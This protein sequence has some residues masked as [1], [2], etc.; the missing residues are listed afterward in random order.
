MHSKLVSTPVYTSRDTCT[1]TG[2]QPHTQ[3]NFTVQ[4]YYQ[5]QRS[6]ANQIS[7][8]TMSM[9]VQITTTLPA[10]NNLMVV[11]R[12]FSTIS[13]QW[14]PLEDAQVMS[15]VTDCDDILFFQAYLVYQMIRGQSLPVTTTS[16]SNFMWTDLASGVSMTVAV[17]GVS[18]TGDDGRRSMLLTSTLRSEAIYS[19]NTLY[20]IMISQ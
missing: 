17:A 3:Y 18:S 15:I 10:P 11:N 2:L 6:S 12:T 19:N 20:A 14:E 13:L 7:A 5:Q 8:F 9:P 16:Q 1:L 4:A